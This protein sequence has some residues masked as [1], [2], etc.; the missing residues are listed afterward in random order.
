VT[1]FHGDPQRFEAVATVVATMFPNARTAVDVAGGQGM[2][3][4]IL[5]KHHNIECDVVD[6]R[7]WTLRGVSARAHEYTADM[8]DY[9]DIVVGLHPDDALREV[10]LSAR[11]RPVVVIPCCNF[12]SRD[13]RLGRLEL[14][15]AIES[16][17]APTGSAQRTTF[18]FRGPKNLGLILHPPPQHRRHLAW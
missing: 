5:T 14:L 8:A 9:Y 11:V 13:T 16:F 17:H 18:D 2:L 12:W 7:G 3:A 6:P 10:V 4:R 1:H 15:D